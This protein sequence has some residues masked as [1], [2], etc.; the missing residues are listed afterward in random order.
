MVCLPRSKSHVRIGDCVL[1]M[2]ELH[3]TY[4]MPDAVTVNDFHWSSCGQSD[5]LREIQRYPEDGL[6]RPQLEAPAA[7]SRASSS[8]ISS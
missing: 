7:Q 3:N 4:D 2:V 8:S 1:E 6:T 5:A